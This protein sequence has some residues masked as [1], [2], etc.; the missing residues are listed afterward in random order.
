[1]PKAAHCEV[2]PVTAVIL[3]GGKGQRLQG[4]DKGLVTLGKQK[5]IEIVLEQIASNVSSLIINANR[6]QDSYWQ[7]ADKY[8]AQLISDQLS[9]FQGPLAGVSAALQ[10]A[11]TSHILTLPCDGPLISPVYIERM[12]QLIPR[13]STHSTLSTEPTLSANTIAIAH[14]GE[15]LQPVHA[16][17]PVT[18]RDDLQ[19]FLQAGNRK[20]RA[21]YTRHSLHS[22]DFSDHPELFFNINT[23]AQLEHLEQH[24]A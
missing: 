20:T 9:D 2:Y 7:Y 10:M 16:L 5:I 12:C 3:A 14:D 6:N 17:I 11:T 8:D 4:Q 21:W 18:L 24:H 19:Q 22:V 15:H 13:A 1:M 23:Q